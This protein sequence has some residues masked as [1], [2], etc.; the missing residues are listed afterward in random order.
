MASIWS[1][2]CPGNT[3]ITSGVGPRWGKSHKGIDISAPKGAQVIATRDG[4]VTRAT[5]ACSHNYAKPINTDSCGGGY[6][7]HIYIDHGDGY[8]SRYAHLTQLNVKVGD[9]VKQG[10]VIGT[11]GSTGNS[12]GFHLHFEIRN[13]ST[14]LD[15]EQYVN[16]NNSVSYVNYDTPEEIVESSD[17]YDYSGNQSQYTDS[18]YSDVAGT[19]VGQRVSGVTTQPVFAFINIWLGDHL[20]STDPERP[21][22]IQSLE[23]DYLDDAGT[24]ATFTLFDDNWEDIEYNLSLYWKEIYI[25]YGYYGTGKKS[26]RLKYYIE[27]YSLEYKDTGVILS[28]KAISTEAVDNL[29][30]ISSQLDTYN[31]TEAAKEICRNLGYAVYDENFDSSQDIHA[32]NPFNLIEDYPITYIVNTIIP[33]ASQENEELFY[34]HVEYDEDVDNYIAYFKRKSFANAKTDS[35][36]TYIYQKGYDSSVIDFYITFKGLLFDGGGDGEEGSHHLD[37]NV[38]SIVIGKESKEESQRSMDVQRSITEATGLVSHA[39]VNNSKHIIDAAGYTESQMDNKLYYRVKTKVNKAYD[40]VITIVGD[41][42]IRLWSDGNQPYI[43][44]IV[45]TDRGTLHHTSG[46]YMINKITHKITEGSM[47]TSLGVSR[48][49]TSWDNLEGLEIIN[50]K[51]LIK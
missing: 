16:P 47:T 33:Q 35:M 41:P 17:N 37:K 10:Q 24:E 45:M 4:K 32:D 21:N 49:A 3:T 13:G 43:R 15:P 2:P 22:I 38:E 50:P 28:V 23:V 18:A 31:P 5:T 11:V 46:V 8:T 26:K 34:F 7:N 36:R 39:L 25:Q 1:W 14:V 20:L 51:L 27:D 48:A 40:G 6:G 42:T 29:T 9:T 44:I 30:P 12:T 19:T